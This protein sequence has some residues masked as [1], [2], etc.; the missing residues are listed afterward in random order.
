[1]VKLSIVLNEIFKNLKKMVVGVGCR[2]IIMIEYIH[3]ICIWYKDKYKNA[4]ICVFSVHA[5]E[6]PPKV[7][8]SAGN[9]LFTASGSNDQS[10]PITVAFETSRS[11]DVL[12]VASERM[13]TRARRNVCEI[14][15]F[16]FNHFSF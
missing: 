10:W 1:M 14:L 7:R 5:P 2:Y 16:R 11:L 12:S 8:A 6:A 13:K 4:A 3:I 15:S 9:K